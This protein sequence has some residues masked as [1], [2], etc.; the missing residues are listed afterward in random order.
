V[1]GQWQPYKNLGASGGN[2]F[3]LE[4]S[5]AEALRHLYFWDGNETVIVEAP[6]DVSSAQI[7]GSNIQF[8]AKDGTIYKKYVALVQEPEYRWVKPAGGG[9]DDSENWDRE[10]VPS[11]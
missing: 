9:W 2:V 4:Y 11:G 5:Y 1:V 3:W 8:S 6:G 7:Y 10:K